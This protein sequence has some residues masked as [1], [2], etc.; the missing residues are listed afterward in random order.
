MDGPPERASLS[1]IPTDEQPRP[2]DGP[3]VDESI[4]YQR[5]LNEL[6]RSDSYH[7]QVIGF[8]AKFAYEFAVKSVPIA[9]VVGVGLSCRWLGVVSVGYLDMLSWGAGISVSLTLVGWCMSEGDRSVRAG[10]TD[11]RP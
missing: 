1:P 2:D 6:Y 8:W 10:S 5:R 9:L 4:S 7:E 3:V 11:G